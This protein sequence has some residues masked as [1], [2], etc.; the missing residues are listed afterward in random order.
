MP[1][2]TPLLIGTSVKSVSAVETIKKQGTQVM[3]GGS[4]VASLRPEKTR[5]SSRVEGK[6]SDTVA[7]RGHTNH[8]GTQGSHKDRP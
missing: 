3:G 1:A 4:C 2:G 7:A 5:T 6:D 8:G